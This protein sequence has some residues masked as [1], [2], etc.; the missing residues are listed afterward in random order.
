MSRPVTSTRRITIG[1]TI[2]EHRRSLPGRTALVDGP[3]R[4]TWPEF[5]E[6]TNRLANALR[7]VGVGP[8]DRILWLGQNSFRVYELL[9]AA[10]KLGA[11]VCPGYWRWAA[12]E[13]AFVVEDFDP[14]VVVWQDEEI[15]DTVRKARAELGG[16]QGALWLRHDTVGEGRIR[17]SP[18]SP[19]GRRTTPAT[20][21]TRTP[22]SW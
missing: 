15:G 11:M 12:P 22:R 1:D 8:G 17:T 3:V 19:P 10:A 16:G 20:T 18:S 9:G 14:R 4:L 6:R 13:M 7:G 2:R 5:D 21:S